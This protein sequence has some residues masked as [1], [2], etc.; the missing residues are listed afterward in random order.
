MGQHQDKLANGTMILPGFLQTVT[1]PGGIRKI[2]LRETLR[3][4]EVARILRCNQTTVHNMIDDGTL[5]AHRLTDRARS[6]YVISK[7]SINMYLE[8]RGLTLPV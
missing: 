3:V 8:K 5:T 6:V 2:E 1:L 4:S 7:A